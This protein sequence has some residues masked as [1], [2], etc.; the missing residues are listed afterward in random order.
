MT[1]RADIRPVRDTETFKDALSLLASPL[2]L[3]TTAD[4]EGNR[5]G[6]TASSVIS[7]S[8]SPPL[9]VVGIARTSSCAAAFAA[10]SEFVVNVLGEQH[11]ELAGRFAARGID[12]FAG[13]SVAD[14]PGSRLPFVPD[15][16][17][18]FR[19][20]VADR[21]RVGDHDLL[22]GRPTEVLLDGGS[23]PLLWHRRAF[24]TTA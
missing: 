5:W 19:C 9:V 15:A 21:L 13:Q 24:R 11:R 1:V 18:A 12:R 16:H 20:A 2:T 8:L 17:A 22:V 3:V 7:A 10:A 14:W 6:L 23:P 4:E